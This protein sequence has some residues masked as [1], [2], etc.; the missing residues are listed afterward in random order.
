MCYENLQCVYLDIRTV[1]TYIYNLYC[2]YICLYSQYMRI[3][4]MVTVKIN[5]YVYIYILSGF[6]MSE[7]LSC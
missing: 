1:D 6:T 2:I 4:I 7:I 3:E 5:E